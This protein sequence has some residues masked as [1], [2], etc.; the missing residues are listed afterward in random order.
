MSVTAMSETQVRKYR[1]FCPLSLL[2]L[3][4]QNNRN[5]DYRTQN[6]GGTSTANSRKEFK[7][8]FQNFNFQENWQLL[9]L[10]IFVEWVEKKNTPT[11]TNNM[12]TSERNL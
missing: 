6:S 11:Y 4:M 2:F 9:A 5:L 1:L 7:N 12:W 10:D 3:Y 8:Q